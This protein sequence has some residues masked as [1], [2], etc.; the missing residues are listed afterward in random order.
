M[1]EST[2]KGENQEVTNANPTKRLK[3][4]VGGIAKLVE[5]GE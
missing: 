2:E 4:G 5:G 3:K 1:G